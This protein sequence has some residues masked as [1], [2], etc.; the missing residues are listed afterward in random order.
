MPE[1][2]K[3]MI[4]PRPT[5]RG[6]RNSPWSA[7]RNAR[8]SH[9]GKTVTAG[10]AKP[11]QQYLLSESYQR[12]HCVSQGTPSLSPSIFIPGQ[13]CK[14][15]LASLHEVIWEQYLRPSHL[16]GAGTGLGSVAMEEAPL[17]CDTRVS[18]Q[19]C[20]AGESVQANRPTTSATKI[21][22]ILIH[23]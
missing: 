22:F 9:E 8:L 2:K 13:F 10:G 7:G 3:L 1:K 18:A 17:G 11:R 15:F 21:S 6:L 5:T 23:P 14:K 20:N 4:C 16:N 19:D 12:H